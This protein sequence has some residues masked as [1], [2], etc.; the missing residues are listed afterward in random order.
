MEFSHGDG[1]W[2]QREKS[3]LLDSLG[4]MVI[5]VG[6]YEFPKCNV[7]GDEGSKKII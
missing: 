3:P 1:V 5:I 2:S 6:K 7:M 4:N